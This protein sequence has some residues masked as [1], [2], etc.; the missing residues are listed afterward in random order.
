M[1]KRKLENLVK[2]GK[3]YYI[4]FYDKQTKQRVRISTGTDIEDVAKEFRNNYFYNLKYNSQRNN[5][6]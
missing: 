1:Q 3:K 5:N 2:R 4:D 6:V